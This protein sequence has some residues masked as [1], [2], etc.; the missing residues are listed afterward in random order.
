[1]RL[2]L[3]ESPDEL[4]QVPGVPYK[5]WILALSTNATADDVFKQ[6][7]R[8]LEKAKCDVLEAGQNF[9]HNVLAT[10]DWI[11]VIPRRHRDRDGQLP[12]NGAGMLGL[13]WCSSQDEKDGWM[14]RAMTQ[15]LAHVG[16]PC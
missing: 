2:V 1:M 11:L 5:H 12:T 6:Y 16:F 10:R 9:A 7:S 13:M 4:L 14:N 8:L 15:H 3:T